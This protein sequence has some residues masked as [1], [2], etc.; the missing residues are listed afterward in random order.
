MKN[1][2][3]VTLIIL[4]ITIILLLILTF[5]ISVNVTDISN[6]KRKTNFE[7]DIKALK[8]E[9]DQYYAKN[10]S[11]PIINKYTNIEL[12]KLLCYRFIKNKSKFKLWKRL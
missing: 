2:K 7:N 5:T 4:V 3:G 6:R 8:E 11:L 1:Q 12:I 10:E 9:I